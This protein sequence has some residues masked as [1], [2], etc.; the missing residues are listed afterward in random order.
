MS[1]T[2][3]CCVF[4][5]LSYG[6]T[7]MVFVINGD[8][9]REVVLTP[10]LTLTSVYTGTE[11]QVICGLYHVRKGE[12]VPLRRTGAFLLCA[13]FPYLYRCTPFDPVLEVRSLALCMCQFYVLQ[14]VHPEF[15]L[16]FLFDGT[17]VA[18]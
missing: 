9:R 8:Q 7:Q 18:I 14:P 17:A 4:K 2:H 16:P 15:G 5:H 10:I 11:G 12:A 13:S 3:G 6:R 1:K